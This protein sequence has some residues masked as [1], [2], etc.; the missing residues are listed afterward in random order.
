L[1]FGI[2]FAQSQA[3]LGMLLRSS[4]AKTQNSSLPNGYIISLN[5]LRA[6]AGRGENPDFGCPAKA[7]AGD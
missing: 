6:D 4:L 1:G 3:T 7:V 5:A 2:V